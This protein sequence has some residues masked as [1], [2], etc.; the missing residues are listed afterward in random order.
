MGNIGL[1]KD[2]TST[3]TGW[4]APGADIHRSPFSGRNNEY[5]SQDSLHSGYMAAAV[6]EGVQSK[7]V[8][9]Y[10]KHCFM[11]D[12]ESNRGNLFT[13]ATEQSM[14]ETYTKSFQMALQEGGSKGAMV[15]YG[16]LGGYFQYQQ[17]Q[18]EHR[19]LSE[20][21]GCVRQLR[22]RRL[23]RLEDADGSRHDGAFR[24]RL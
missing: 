21:M 8:V 14:R 1:L 16:R 23:H 6:I 10:V 24:K 5:Y 20:S 3:Q 13:W 11:N 17:L 7:G 2:L 4:Y 12:Q 15:G 19:T 9:C 18:F 22:N